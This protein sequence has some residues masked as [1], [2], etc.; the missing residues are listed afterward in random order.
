M[1][2]SR[3]AIKHGAT[4]GRT[5]LEVLLRG[6]EGRS[7]PA[8]DNARLSVGE[9]VVEGVS[10]EEELAEFEEVGGKGERRRER[11]LIAVK[12]LKLTIPLHLW[13]VPSCSPRSR[14]RD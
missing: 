5:N 8:I 4:G 9:H 11:D 10:R 3:V 2:F 14:R 7:V 1:G 12:R 13:L 6:N